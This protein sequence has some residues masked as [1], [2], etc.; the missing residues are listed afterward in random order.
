ME[1]RTLNDLGIKDS[2]NMWRTVNGIK[3]EHWTSDPMLTTREWEK[4]HPGY[5]FIRRGVEIFRSKD[6]VNK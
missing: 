3:Y 5:K 2:C 4:E 1:I 6:K